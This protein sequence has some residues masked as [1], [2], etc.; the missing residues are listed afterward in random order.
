MNK[1]ILVVG[2]AL[3]YKAY[4]A[5]KTI[6][7]ETD[8]KNEPKLSKQE[9][10]EKILESIKNVNVNKDIEIKE[11]KEIKEKLSVL[12]KE[13]AILHE[14]ELKNEQLSAL[15]GIKVGEIK[16]N[17]LEIKEA[18]KIREDELNNLFRLLKELEKN[19]FENFS[20]SRKK[21]EKRKDFRENRIFKLT[22]SLEEV[23]GGNSFVSL[24][25]TNRKGESY[26]LEEFIKV[27]GKNNKV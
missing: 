19:A 23:F 4:E 13:I 14:L 20:Q 21:E 2:L 17:G 26:S 18:R 7:N 6:D 3:A 22:D 11:I 10:S 1:L 8:Y 16:F 27:F 15:G 5:F 9:I 12:Q 25:P 24:K